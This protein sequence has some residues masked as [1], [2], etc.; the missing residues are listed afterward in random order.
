MSRTPVNH[1]TEIASAI[2]DSIDLENSKVKKCNHF[3]LERKAIDIIS[4]ALDHK[5]NDECSSKVISGKRPSTLAATAVWIA[6]EEMGVK[7]NPFDVSC[8]AQI[9]KETLL[10][11]AETIRGHW[12]AM[13]SF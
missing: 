13:M 2:S 1:I 7:F 5:C 6:S 3:E 9:S 12:S 11:S 10:S 8:C 4:R